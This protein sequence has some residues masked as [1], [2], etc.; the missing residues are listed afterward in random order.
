MVWDASALPSQGTCV[1]LINK[2][3]AP[4]ILDPD[5]LFAMATASPMPG[6]RPTQPAALHS[7][8][9]PSPAAHLKRDLMSGGGI[10]LARWGVTPGRQLVHAHTLPR[11]GE[12]AGCDSPVSFAVALISC[13]Y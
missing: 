9:R 7:N 12:Q 6:T 5:E 11:R 8:R 10:Q 4:H 2:H 1:Y 13:P 3:T